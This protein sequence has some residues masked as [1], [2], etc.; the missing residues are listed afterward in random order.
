[1]AGRAVSGSLRPA[2]YARAGI[3]S[4]SREEVSEQKTQRP[5]TEYSTHL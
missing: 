3:P 4:K 2:L 5:L 1:M